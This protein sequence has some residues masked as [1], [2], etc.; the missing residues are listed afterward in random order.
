MAYGRSP[1]IQIS[2]LVK[3]RPGLSVGK[4]RRDHFLAVGRQSPHY[5][6]WDSQTLLDLHVNVGVNPSRQY[7]THPHF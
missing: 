7:L 4:S 2:E 5:G 1:V 6:R 3:V